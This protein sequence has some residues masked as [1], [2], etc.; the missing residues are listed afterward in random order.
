[1]RYPVFFAFCFCVVLPVA[2][3]ASFFDDDTANPCI[4]AG[5]ATLEP[6]F[7]TSSSPLS[8]GIIREIAS[9]K[10]SIRIAAREF[11]SKPVSDAIA[12]AVH[13]GVDVKIVLNKK[14]ARSIYS[15]AHFLMVLSYTPHVTKGD[16]TLFADY[17]VIDDRDV[18]LGNIAGFIDEEEEKKNFGQVLVIH[19]A[20]D[21]AKRYASHWQA[22]WDASEEMP[23]DQN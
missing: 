7:S 20:P 3:G 17:I 14:S 13:A 18:I 10:K 4:A 1:M 2:A 12:K 22:L 11:T 23:K 5:G 19:N 8:A 16:D 9:A 21:V 15:A 6:E